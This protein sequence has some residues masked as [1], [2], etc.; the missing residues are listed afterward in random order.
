M[1]HGNLKQLEFIND[2]NNKNYINNNS[3]KLNF[4]DK[5]FY[6]DIINDNDF[7]NK[8]FSSILRDYPFLEKL[9]EDLFHSLYKSQ[10]EMFDRENMFESLKIE[11]DLLRE[12]IH[13]DG[14]EQARKSTTSDI[15]LSTFAMKAFQLIAM[16]KC[17]EWTKQSNKNKKIMEKINNSI[18]D[19]N[20]LDELLREMESNP[21]KNTK[22]NDA[23]KNIENKIKKNNNDLKK[24][25]SNNST[26]NSLKSLFSSLKNASH[27][28]LDE[29]NEINKALGSFGYSSSGDSKNIETNAN[30]KDKLKLSDYISKNYLVKSICD[31]LGRIKDSMSNLSKKSSIYG[32]IISEVGYGNKINKVLSSEKAMLCNNLTKNKFFYK[33]SEKKLLEYKTKGIDKRK[34]PIIVCVDIS[35]SMSGNNDIWAKATA[36]AFLDIASKNKRSCCIIP[37]N[38]KIKKISYFIDGK[39]NTDDL[40]KFLKTIASGGTNYEPPLNAALTIIED[41][42][43]RKADILFITD[44]E[45][46]KLSEELAKRISKAKKNKGLVIHG[47]GIGDFSES[48][49]VLKTFSDKVTNIN[50]FNDD[51]ALVELADEVRGNK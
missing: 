7:I 33:Y 49:N 36:L 14:F 47:I 15:F 1:L 34:G 44:G 11:N 51:K 31:T 4:I 25:L 2:K 26:S 32:Q 19:Q 28:A 37:F 40:I 22:L 48:F 27:D 20:K 50:D 18:T 8:S 10:P 30:F 35:G 17:E 42:K 29:T 3:I 45:S 21:N 6:E 12:I 5:E 24:D 41:T 43:F 46:I 9:N 39:K 23:I 38:Y 16:R 13:F